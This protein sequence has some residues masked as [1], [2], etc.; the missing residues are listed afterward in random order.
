MEIT[1]QIDLVST[2]KPLCTVCSTT[3]NRSAPLSSAEE[4]K[5]TFK[6]RQTMAATTQIL[7]ERDLLEISSRVNVLL[8]NFAQR[9]ARFSAALL[10]VCTCVCYARVCA[11]S[12]SSSNNSS[13]S[14]RASLSMTLDDKGGPRLS[15]LSRNGET[16]FR[17]EMS[18]ISTS[19][20]TES[21]MPIL[22]TAPP[23]KSASSVEIEELAT[24]GNGT[25]VC[26][27]TRSTT[28]RAMEYIPR[29]S[30]IM[31]TTAC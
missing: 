28:Q 30:P 1:S 31:T 8:T 14:L 16:E 3:Q 13:L 22:L 7:E 19:F 21:Q 27:Y 24:S 9:L 5:N 23:R 18:K 29:D 6:T 2:K 4:N 11:W 26:V 20:S 10:F 17:V 25:H 12:T 15:L